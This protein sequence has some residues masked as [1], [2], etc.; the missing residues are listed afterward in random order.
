M[1]IL[2]ISNFCSVYTDIGTMPSGCLYTDFGIFEWNC[3]NKVLI[4][5]SGYLSPLV[6]I[7]FLLAYEHHETKIQFVTKYFD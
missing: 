4:S 1:F 3:N 6:L 5:Y 7:H 2:S